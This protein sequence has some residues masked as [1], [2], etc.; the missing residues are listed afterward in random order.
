MTIDILKNPVLY[1]FIAA[2]A[3]YC[4]FK[5]HY[6]RQK[7]HKQPKHKYYELLVASSI[8]L[9]VWFFVSY[10]NNSNDQQSEPQT[11][12][13]YHLVHNNI[14]PAQ[15]GGNNTMAP[16]HQIMIPTNNMTQMPQ[17]LRPNANMMG[18]HMQNNSMDDTVGVNEFQLLSKGVGVPNNL[19]LPEVFIETM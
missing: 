7:K 12:A 17:H 2:I 15:F 6:S 14:M 1:G 3:S 19:K 11:I 13:S 16:N 18:G 10:Y 9:V 4:L 8:G 5:W